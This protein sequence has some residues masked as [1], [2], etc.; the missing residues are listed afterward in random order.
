METKKKALC[1]AS[2]AS[3]LDNFNRNNV[4][5]LQSLGYEVT[6][7]SNFESGEDTNSA[8]KIES[9]VREMKDGGVHI[10]QI[11]FSRSIKNIGG[12]I[13]SYNQVKKLID[14]KFDLIHCHSPI[15]AAYTR[16]CAKKYRNEG[17]SKVIYTAHGFHFYDGAPIK[18]WLIY[19]PAEKTLSR[20]TDVLI[21]IN[22]EDFERARDKFF[23]KEVKYIPGVGIDVRKFIDCN[24][25]KESK[26]KELHISER[27]FVLLSVGELNKNK[28]H[29]VV[30]KALAEVDNP[31]IE[32]CIAGI[33]S[34]MDNLKILTNRLGLSKQVHFLGYRSDVDEL[35][36]MSDAFVFPSIREG[37]GLAALEAMAS[38][39]PI[40]TSKAGG[41]KDYS[42]DGVTG[43]SCNSGDVNGFAHAIRKLE[44]N[45]E[46]CLK[47]GKQNA[48]SALKYDYA[49]VGKIMK[50]IYMS[51]SD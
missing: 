18:N 29:Q 39:L 27:N 4:K 34:E 1:L 25:S 6:L 20:Y 50:D 31:N 12:Q 9:F 51:V 13:K 8:E 5:I 35:C 11:D 43:F 40:V 21:T 3:N 41:I 47:M 22:K 28:N 14:Q 36:R 7:A 19:Y 46:L 17:V 48:S 23:S 45:H 2:M 49:E 30:I 32:Y 26:R 37:L 38:G 16:I 42:I 10:T 24:V 33:G 15:C 44:E